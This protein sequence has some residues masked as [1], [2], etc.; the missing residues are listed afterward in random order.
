MA[1]KANKDQVL[2]LHSENNSVTLTPV[3]EENA[4]M[5]TTTLGVLP[6]DQ[7]SAYYNS[8][9]SNMLYVYHL[10]IPAKVEAENLKSLRKSVILKNV[11]NFERGTGEFDV[12]KW[13]PWI[14][15]LAIL[16]LK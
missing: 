16:L 9:N 3:L 8:S 6:L 14:T 5:L 12:M 7:A 4:N 10:D 1:K 15:A 11:F 2:I 13:M